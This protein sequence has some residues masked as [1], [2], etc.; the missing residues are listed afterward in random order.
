MSKRKESPNKSPATPA[1]EPR[2]NE[3]PENTT[4]GFQVTKDMCT[5]ALLQPDVPCEHTVR[6]AIMCLRD[7]VQTQNAENVAAA[8]RM[9]CIITNSFPADYEFTLP[10]LV[11]QDDGGFHEKLEAMVLNG[12]Y[13]ELEKFVIH[14]CNKSIEHATRM[15]SVLTQLLTT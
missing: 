5:G 11:E 6:F 1:K 10:I 8:F 4:G 3:T 12:K 13:D 2:A 7:A 9:I 15:A 14:C